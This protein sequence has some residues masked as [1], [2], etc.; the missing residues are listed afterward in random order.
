MKF[1]NSV[2]ATKNGFT[3]TLKN[4]QGYGH[5]SNFDSVIFL[6]NWIDLSIASFSVQMVKFPNGFIPNGVVHP[7][8]SMLAWNTVKYSYG[9]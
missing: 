9:F 8:L 6:Y 2:H 1:H 4:L 7:I 3:K 5:S